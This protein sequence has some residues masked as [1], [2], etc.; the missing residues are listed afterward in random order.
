MI[1]SNTLDMPC[2]GIYLS[3]ERCLKGLVWI[4]CSQEVGMANKKAF[5]VVVGVDE[6][7]GD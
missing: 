1:F 2:F 7:A 4:A 6:P 3:F 5:F